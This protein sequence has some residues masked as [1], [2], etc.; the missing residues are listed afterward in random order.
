MADT[1][2]LLI[3]AISIGAFITL[4]LSVVVDCVVLLAK[5]IA[6][7]PVSMNF[8]GRFLWLG[9]LG[10]IITLYFLD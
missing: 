7:E 6:K 9:F 2:K 3:V 8:V 10:M 5:A 4:F 1:I